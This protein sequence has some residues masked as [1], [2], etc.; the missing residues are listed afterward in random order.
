[1]PEW[2]LILNNTTKSLI[3]SIADEGK[4]GD[5]SSEN[6]SD[7]DDVEEKRQT[8]GFSSP[9]AG[10]GGEEDNKEDDEASYT[11]EY[12]RRSKLNCLI[13]EPPVDEAAAAK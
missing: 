10:S 1:M 2:K 11:R 13:P 4:P 12:T 6:N 3:S 9:E 5:S 8:P 7:H